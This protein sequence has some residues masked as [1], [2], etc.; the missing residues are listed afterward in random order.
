M[1][2]LASIVAS[3]FANHFED[4]A[5]K[6][7]KWVEPVTYHQFWKNPYGYGNSIGHLVLHLTGNLNYYI[8]AQVAGSGYVRNRDLEFTDATRPL[9]EEVL[10]A[11]DRA[12][13]LVVATVGKQTAADWSAEYS[14]ERS[15]GKNRFAILLRCAAHADHHLGQIIYLS[16]ELARQAESRVAS[17]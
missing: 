3:E 11:F 2:D 1:S 15:E 12:I 16:K 14:A 5:V 17:H 13:Q 8:G 6:L 9:K 7:R 4:A 10:R